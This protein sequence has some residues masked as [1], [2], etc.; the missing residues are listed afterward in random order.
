MF[1]SMPNLAITLSVAF[2]DKSFTLN[3]TVVF[4][5]SNKM[6]LSKSYL[7]KGYFMFVE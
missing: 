5:V 4:P 1:I 3:D 6:V 2:E 7:R